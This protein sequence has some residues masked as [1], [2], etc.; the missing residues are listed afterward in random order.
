MLIHLLAE[1]PS[2]VAPI[3][4]IVEPIHR[5]VPINT[6]HKG[7]FAPGDVVVIDFDLRNETSVAQVREFLRKAGKIRHKLFVID[8]NSHSLVVQAHALEATGTIFRPLNRDDV[9]RQLARLEIT[10]PPNVLQAVPSIDLGNTAAIFESLFSSI[11]N[12]TPIE[13]AD[14]KRATEQIIASVSER[15]LTAWLDD[16]RKHHEGTFQHCL[17][18][19]GIATSFAL[20]LGF[21]GA[22]VY[23]LGLA[24]TL[25]DV[26]KA[27]IPLAILDKPG[28]LDA[29]EERIMRA[30]P[31]YGFEALRAMEGIDKEV[32]DAV[33][34]H[35]EFLDGTGYPDALSAP[36]IPDIV[37]L[38]TISDIFAALIEARSYK[39]P[40]SRPKAYDILNEMNGKLEP[41]LVRAFKPV[42]LS[43]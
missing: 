13:L 34:H 12:G 21:T 4:A 42:A 41:A 7:G 9:L 36:A 27:N 15:G 19:S 22:D 10:A 5:L 39:T 30:H 31:V 8:K 3:R 35:H 1:S 23:R 20:N 11:V 6:D 17:L 43:A 25:H 28:R 29:E 24:A 37:R 2:R 18:V 33:R 26:G 40:M 38:L 32:L 16:V 14:A